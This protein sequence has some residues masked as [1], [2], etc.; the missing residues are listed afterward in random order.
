VAS[1]QLDLL[2]F[3]DD[4][5]QPPLDPSA[6]LAPLSPVLAAHAA[7]EGR[8]SSDLLPSF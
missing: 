6:P 7:N 8:G 2:G 4:E 1:E 3:G 5:G